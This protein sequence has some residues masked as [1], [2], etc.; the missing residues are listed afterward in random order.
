MGIIGYE[1]LMIG[2]ACIMAKA[3]W[4]I[5]VRKYLMPLFFT[6][7]FGFIS[8]ALW[9]TE[10]SLGILFGILTL[11]CLFLLI[12]VLVT[13]KQQ[14]E[15]TLSIPA[16]SYEIKAVDRAG[17]PAVQLQY[18]L[19]YHGKTYLLS[20]MPPEGK[21]ALLLHTRTQPCSD[22]VIADIAVDIAG[23][24]ATPKQRLYQLHGALVMI[25]A[26]FLPIAYVMYEN[27]YLT[28][29]LM[30]D[31]IMIALGYFTASATRGSQSLLHRLMHWF[32]VLLEAAG[33]IAML[34][35]IC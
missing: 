5:S 1:L 7:G 28:Q 31:C 2:F 13:P 15:E 24:T 12:R 4:L 22:T 29:N 16:G 26:L 32:A 6:A 11:L 21:P 9:N 33:W 3:E 20:T 19:L 34:I 25:A 30:P 10:P 8:I 27:G 14:I 23:K 17:T 18:L 35:G